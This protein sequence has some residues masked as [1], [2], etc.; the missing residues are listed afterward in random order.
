MTLGRQRAVILLEA[1]ISLVVIAGVAGACL[2]LRSRALRQRVA[3]Q[4]TLALDDA[5][6]A[7]LTLAWTWPPLLEPM[8]Q[9]IL[10]PPPGLVL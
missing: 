10:A 8:P 9:W 5:L 6:T 2:G 3:V 4:E 1:I 7:I